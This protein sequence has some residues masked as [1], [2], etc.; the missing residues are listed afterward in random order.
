VRWIRSH[1]KLNKMVVIILSGTAHQED[2]N[3]A[4]RSG[5]NSFLLKSPKPG[6][7]H[8]TV[9]LIQSYWLNQNFSS[10]LQPRDRL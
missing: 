5:A 6:H 8:K 7:L 4:Y 9:D 2:V 3:E 10:G 1:P